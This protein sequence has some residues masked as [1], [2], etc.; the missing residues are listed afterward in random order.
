[1]G[2]VLKHGDELNP[3]G[4]YEDWISHSMIQMMVN[5]KSFHIDTWLEAMNLQHQNCGSWGVKD[6]WILFLQPYWGMFE[7]ELV[8][9]CERN[10]EA[11][12]RSWLKVWES[13]N[14]G[15]QPP[16]EVINYYIKL[17][18]DRQ[19]LCEET[20]KIWP[21]Y[22]TVNFNTQQ[23][24]YEISERIEAKLSAAWRQRTQIFLESHGL[25]RDPAETQAHIDIE[26]GK[27]VSDTD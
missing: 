6:P 15:Q 3:K 21:N 2:H 23:K 12:V 9:Y 26:T 1:M 20:K 19:A 27:R 16:Q 11:T 18:N 24:E 14:P 7:P 10:T 17:T 13:S 5:N 22:L 4:Y 8:I 25:V